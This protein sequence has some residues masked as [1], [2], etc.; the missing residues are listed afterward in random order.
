MVNEVHDIDGGSGGAASEEPSGTASPPSAQEQPTPPAGTDVPGG[1][2]APA[3]PPTV[4]YTVPRPGSFAPPAG[5]GGG[6]YLPPPPA[7][8]A[9]GYWQAGWAATSQGWA[10]PR[11][12]PP[13]GSG[14][15]GRTLALLLAAVLLLV[16]GVAIGH[17]LWTATSSP[18]SSSAPGLVPGPRAQ[19][20]QPTTPGTGSG[21]PSDI[22]T[23]ASKVDP[24]LV[25]I[26]TTLSYE[27]EEAAGTGMV[28]TPSGEI[29]TNNHVIE[30]ATTISVTDVGNGQTYTATVVGYDSTRDLAVLQLHGASGLKTVSIGN[31]SDVS[32]GQ[33][34][35]GIGNA[36]GTGGTPSSA[37]GSVTA[38]NQSITAGEEDDG[39]SEQLSNLIESNADIQPGDSG[40]PLVNDN[41]QVLGIDTAASAGFEFQAG[42][43]GGYSIPINE[44]IT[45]ATQIEA[46]R[47]SS[48]IHIG[49]TG[50]LGV[51]VE[52][53][54]TSGGFGGGGGFGDG[55]FGSGGIGGGGGSQVTGAAVAGVVTGDPADEAG[56]STGDVITGLAGTTITSA[57]ALTD[58]LISYHPGDKVQIT[59]TD[60]SGQSHTATVQLASGPPA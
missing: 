1:P 15:A 38:L 29:L 28:L 45:V 2:A 39:S 24:G 51:E 3:E 49:L 57:G 30:G 60:Q 13:T 19:Q 34:V 17:G 12:A 44:A 10:P 6:G 11:V 43:G 9:P 20:Q 21:A 50:F 25:D 22:S 52:P 35:V 46:G 31:S 42:A 36:G 7:A 41:G 53:T 47:G 40:G 56:I 27:E 5:S 26:N 18:A 58:A 8:D 37:G 16:A 32:V 4:P 48:T 14:S 59:W 54:G 33:S 55:G 23:I